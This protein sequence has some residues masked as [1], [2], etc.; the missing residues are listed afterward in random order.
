[1]R[2][3]ALPITPTYQVQCDVCFGYMDGSY[4]TREDAEDARKELGWEDTNR[5]TACPEHNTTTDRAAQK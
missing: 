1:V 5:R 4:D 3:P 2:T